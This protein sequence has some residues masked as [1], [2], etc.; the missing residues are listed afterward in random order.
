MMH[1]QKN[2]KFKVTLTFVDVQF[3][4]NTIKKDWN[5]MTVTSDN[6]RLTVIPA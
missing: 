4:I 6:H 2:I 5:H 1:D 3:A